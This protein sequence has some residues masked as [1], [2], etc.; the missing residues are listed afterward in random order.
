MILTP[1][2][3]HRRMV[4]DRKPILQKTLTLPKHTQLAL[5][6]TVLTALPVWGVQEGRIHRTLCTQTCNINPRQF[7]RI[8]PRLSPT[9][10][11]EGCQGHMLL[12]L[13]IHRS[14]ERDA[15]SVWIRKDFKTRWYRL[16]RFSKHKSATCLVR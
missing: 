1:L 13:R 10:I 16:L 5:C 2:P 7:H 3:M 14:R 9:R 4:C 11:N 15:K 6:S 12:Q 8:I